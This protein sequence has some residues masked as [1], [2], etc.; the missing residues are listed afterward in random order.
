[1]VVKLDLV[2]REY[3]HTRVDRSDGGNVQK[4]CQRGLNGEKLCSEL[5]CRN[6]EV[7]KDKESADGG[8]E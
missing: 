8:R 2:L 1:M 4:G 3:S 7:S 5:K 6:L